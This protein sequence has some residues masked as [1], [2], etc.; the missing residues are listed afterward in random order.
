[1][2]LSFDPE[3]L[4][5]NVLP[6]SMPEWAKAL[7]ALLPVASVQYDLALLR[8]QQQLLRQLGGRLEQQGA[9]PFLIEHLDNVAD[10][11]GALVT[12][13]LKKLDALGD[14]ATEDIEP[15]WLPDFAPLPVYWLPADPAVEL[16]SETVEAFDQVA[17]RPDALISV[18]GGVAEIVYQR[19]DLNVEIVDYDNLGQEQAQQTINRLLGGIHDVSDWI[20]DYPEE[21][22][23]A[24][25]ENPGAG[26]VQPVTQAPAEA[27]PATSG[28][29]QNAL[30]I[31]SGQYAT[32]E[33]VAH[34]MKADPKKAAKLFKELQR[35]WEPKPTFFHLAMFSGENDLEKMIQG[36]MEAR[37]NTCQNN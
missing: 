19:P 14:N 35:V 20:P 25:D 7:G 23:P 29:S 1:M 17:S 12:P 3:T 2:K 9:A 31:A 6:T 11:L 34:V 37:K 15:G 21:Q 16:S 28:L 30:I 26:T 24:A 13:Y 32:V 33:D 27:A 4:L 5:P 10:L 22:E 8:R 36:L 18:A